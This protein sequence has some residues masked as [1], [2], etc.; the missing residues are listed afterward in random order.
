MA[1]RASTR[2]SNKLAITHQE[3]PAWATKSSEDEVP[4]NDDLREKIERERGPG[5]LTGANKKVDERDFLA[6]LKKEGVGTNADAMQQ[7]SF[8]ERPAFDIAI[9]SAIIMNCIILGLEIDLSGHS[10]PALW[11]VFENFFCI[12]WI[13]EMVLKIYCLRI[14]YFKDLWNYLEPDLQ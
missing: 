9:A 3:N 5:N 11:I 7:R 6:V 10:P 8:V 13:V 1:A 14:L 12:C 2:R 4:D